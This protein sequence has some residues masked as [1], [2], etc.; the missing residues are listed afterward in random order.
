[1]KGL[2][3]EEAFSKET[4]S[5]IPVK[6]ISSIVMKPIY[7]EI[8]DEQS[9]VTSISAGSAA[10]RFTKRYLLFE[11]NVNVASGDRVLTTDRLYLIPD[12]AMLQAN[13]H[14]FLKISDKQWEGHGLTTDVLLNPLDSKEDI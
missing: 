12:K 10:V 4:F 1:M 3:F 6:R 7:V 2:T 5:S 11:K 14:F 9:I 13:G 8:H